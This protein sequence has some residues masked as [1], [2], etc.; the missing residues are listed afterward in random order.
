MKGMHCKSCELLLEESLREV[1]GVASVKVSLGTKQA[2][3]EPKE[4]APRMQ[5]IE[6]AIQSA[7][8]R[9]GTDEKAPWLSKE[10]KTYTNLTKAAVILL[11]I[12]FV[13]RFFGL[14]DLAITPN[15][16][17]A[18]FAL[19]IGLIAG[20]ST[21]MALVGGLVLGLSARHAEA[22]PEATPAQKFRPHLYFNG[23]RIV[24]YAVLGGILGSIGSVIRFSPAF[25]AVLTVLIGIVM[26]FLGLKLTGLSP[27]LKDT[28]ITLPS[29]LGKALGF[30]K[31]TGEYHPLTTM[32]TGALTFFL[33]C[34]FTQAMQVY[35]VGTGSFRSGALAMGLFA[36]GTAPALLGAGGLAAATKKR[37]ATQFYAVIG[38]AVLLFGGYNIGNT[39]ALHGVSLSAF[40]GTARV[41]EKATGFV[42][43]MQDGYQ[44]L[45]MR[46]KSNGY[47]P[48]KL[49]I[50]RGIPVKWVIESENEYTCAASIYSSAFNINESLNRG[51]NT[52]EFT[53]TSSG[54]F[55]FSCSM[56][57]Y[58]G[59]ITVID[60]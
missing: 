20:V 27:R 43:E 45:R 3:I 51:E 48:S 54:T 53:P 19:A 38:L 12:F 5:D 8:Y 9:I 10:K 57:M 17:T 13:A 14:T 46:Q 55:P 16:V 25:L 29:S 58:R 11:G 52:I 31:Q 56:G 60:P 7:G 50:V 30:N 1:E 15:A 39:L 18:P 59:T 26:I 24:G 44:I 23:G 42:P 33:P 22:H 21:C 2:V 4:T 41:E 32:M 36:L 49:T 35:A 28:S 40:K 37:S 47:S 34:G 6:A